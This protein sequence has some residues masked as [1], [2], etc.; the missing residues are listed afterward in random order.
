MFNMRCEN[1]IDLLIKNGGNIVAEKEEGSSST[2][3][4]KTIVIENQTHKFKFGFLNLGEKQ[5]IVQKLYKQKEGEFWD[6]LSNEIFNDLLK[7][8]RK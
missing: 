4:G 7:T 2:F 8:K 6:N 5:I 3:C 1:L